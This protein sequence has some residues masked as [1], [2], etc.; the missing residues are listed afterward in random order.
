[1]LAVAQTTT[2]VPQQQQ[3]QQEQQQQVVVEL[4]LEQLER[5][6]QEI[7]A[8]EAIYGFE[9]G[10]FTVHSESELLA[11]RT[12]VEGQVAPPERAAAADVGQ[13]LD[14]ELQ[15]SLEEVPGAPW[16]RL[17]FSLPKGYPATA[18]TASVSVS[19]LS[20]AAADRLSA[21]LT[22]RAAA[23]AGDEAVMELVQYFQET[24][25]AAI[26]DATVEQQNGNEKDGEGAA[27]R[28]K[29]VPT[30][31][32]TGRR[33]IWVHHI[34]DTERRRSIVVEAQELRLGGYLKS[35][36][37][38]IIVVEGAVHACDEFVKWLKGSKSRPN[39]FGRNWGHHVRGES[40][41]SED[42][43]LLPKTF[44]ELGEDMGALGA[45]CSKSGLEA[46]FRQY[47][48]Q[49]KPGVDDSQQQEEQEQQ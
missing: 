11:A 3:Q 8:L 46:D 27:G 1:M 18:A 35:G 40:N 16:A 20:R 7:E 21:Q 41:R 14:V 44:E 17:R 13:Q 36:Y 47:V 42:G 9:E 15:I 6:V 49:H 28:A 19:G 12:I 34:T 25:P 24:A 43:R 31:T 10:G 37:P 45:A 39:G 5:A 22:E 33:W 4:E 26:E 30:A 29:A 48:L 23:L 38:G 32:G 2:T